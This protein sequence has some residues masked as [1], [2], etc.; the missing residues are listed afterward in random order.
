MSNKKGIPIDEII[1]LYNNGKNAAEI[2]EILHCDVSNVT[3]RLRKQGIQYK[4]DSTRVRRSRVGRVSINTSYFKN[5]DTPEKAYFLGVLCSD[6]SIRKNVFYL[7]LKDSDVVYKLKDA[8]EC[9]YKVRVCT[10]PY[11]CYI[12]SVYCQEMCN[13]LISLGCTPNKTRTLQLPKLPEYLYSHFVRGYIDGNGCIRVGAF[14]S[15]DMLDIATASSVFAEQ[16][17]AV[18]EPHANHVGITKEKRYDVWHVRCAGKQVKSILD[19]VYSDSDNVCMQRKYF[20]YQLISS[21]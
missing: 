8:L 5:I 12:L 9:A 14:P 4:R 7:K 19:W 15:K 20:K 16:L 3:R 10:S 13:D 6:G 21:R 2:S 1:D 11:E 17:K 18:I